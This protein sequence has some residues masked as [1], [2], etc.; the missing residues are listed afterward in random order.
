MAHDGNEHKSGLYLSISTV[1]T[2]SMQFYFRMEFLLGHKPKVKCTHQ[3]GDE[4]N[5]EFV[6]SPLL[7]VSSLAVRKRWNCDLHSGQPW[8]SR[9]LNCCGG[10]ND[11]MTGEENST[12]KQLTVTFTSDTMFG[13]YSPSVVKVFH[14]IIQHTSRNVQTP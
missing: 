4:F 8:G 10:L 11:G 7:S 13:C 9:K 6:T 2:M 1:Y 3:T 14:T 5:P 12:Y